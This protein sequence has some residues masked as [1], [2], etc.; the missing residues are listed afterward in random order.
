MAHMLIYQN[1]S[2]GYHDPFWDESGAILLSSLM[3][4]L[5]YHRRESEQTISMVLALLSAGHIDEY[6]GGQSP[7]DLIMEKLR[8]EEGECWAY[9]QYSKVKVSATKTWDSILV[10]LTSKMHNFDTEE[11]E[12]MMSDDNIELASIGQKKTALF[13]VVSDTDRSMDNIAN[14]LFTQTMN[15]LCLYADECCEDNVLPVPVRF[16]MDDFATNCRINEFP[17]M[18]ASIRSRGIS[19]ML[20]IQAESQLQEGYGEDWRTII[21]NC[22]TY[23]YLGGNDVETA[24]EVSKRCN[25]P[26]NSVLNM[27][28]G[29]NWIFR[30]GQ[31]P[32]N[33]KNFELEPFLKEKMDS[34]KDPCR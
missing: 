21:G 22:D 10:S 26:L 18:I 13:I 19:T 15:E 33:G 9:R 11:L 16:I 23:V 1:G 25:K 27:P 5:K 14:L 3:A 28:V 34:I 2:V 31:A 32:V 4:Y 17:R 20:M 12:I 8:Q 29:T 24:E 30:R 6:S 7:L